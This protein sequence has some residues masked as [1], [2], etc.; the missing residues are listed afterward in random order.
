MFIFD[1]KSFEVGF[2]LGLYMFY[3][4]S[5]WSCIVIWDVILWYD[6]VY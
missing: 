3:V 4:G 2:I 5:C 6:V 1:D